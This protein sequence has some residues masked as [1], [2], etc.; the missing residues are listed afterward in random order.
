MKLTVIGGG[1]VRTPLLVASTLRRAARI[2]LD[3]LCLMDIDAEKLDL[4]G[5]LCKL[6]AARAGTSVK[7]TTTTDPRAALEGARHV[8]TTIRVGQEQGR[9]TDERIALRHHVLGQETTGPGG[10]AMALRSIP[11]LLDYAH[12]LEEVSPGA[13]MFNFTNPAGLVAQALRDAGFSRTVGIC[14]GANACQHTVADWLKVDP[15]RLRPEVFGLNHLSWT[16]RVWLDGREVLADLLRNPDFLAHSS[17]AIFDP[18]LVEANNLWMNEYLFYFHYAERAV[19]SILSDEKTRG[20]EVLE[21]N[22]HLLRQLG[23]I[24]IERDPQAAL[25]VYAAYEQRRGSTYMHYARTDAPSMEEADEMAFN[26]VFDLGAGE[27]YAGVALGLIEALETGTPLNIA[28]NVPNEGAI[29]GMRPE[30]VVEI[31]VTVDRNGVHPQTI[32]AIPEPQRILMQN[33][34]YYERLTV[35]AIRTRSR[36]T[37]IRALMAHPLVLSYSLATVL[38]VVYLAAYKEYVGSWS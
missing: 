29:E 13:W 11:A 4:I 32:G 30:D 17:M 14:D 3:E 16:R 24:D 26:N 38:V 6:V 1:G 23:Q 33:V 22:H 34:K 35:E 28:V 15:N 2:D 27:G 18:T 8:I 20:E 7:I 37:A 5:R 31:S 19:Q 21:L 25:N 36:Q 9:V 10:F 12:L